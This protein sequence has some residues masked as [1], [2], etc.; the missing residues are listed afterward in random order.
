VSVFY[1][2]VS[3]TALALLADWLLGDPSWIPHP[4]RAIG[5]A[6]EQGES[7]LYSGSPRQDLVNGAVLA[8]SVIALSA[9]AAYALLLSAALFG[10]FVREG[11]AVALGWT[12]LALRGLDEA[13]RRVETALRCNDYAAARAA[14]PSLVGRD[15]ET[16]NLDGIVRATVESVAENACDGVIAPLIFLTLGGPVMAIAYKAINTLDSMIGYRDRRYLFFGRFA[17]RLDDVANYIPARFT[18]LCIVVVSALMGRGRQAWAAVRMSGRCHPS[19]NAGYPESAMAGA[20]GIQLGGP[21][22]YD[23]EL[24]M[25]PF[26][27]V[28]EREAGVSD[29]RSARMM[30]RAASLTAFFVLVVARLLILG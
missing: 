13:A 8:V 23:G 30:L 22:S 29:I 11:V 17:A 1:Q 10:E 5:W 24:E 2:P 27:G 25:R 19:P 6:I 28:A 14:L 18:A 3:L 4:V 7:W 9:A 16:L 15:P 26:L 20:L 21:A 12:T